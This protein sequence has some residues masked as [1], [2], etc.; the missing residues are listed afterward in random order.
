MLGSKIKYNLSC[1]DKLCQLN[2][3]K[4]QNDKTAV[5]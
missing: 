2:N 3:E 4:R 5:G 1:L